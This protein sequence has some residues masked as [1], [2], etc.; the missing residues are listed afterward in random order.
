MPEKL[1]LSVDQF[2][3]SG[4]FGRLMRENVTTGE[5]PFRK[6]WLQAIVDQVEVSADV[7]RIVGDKASLQA[8]IT[9]SSASTVA[10][11]S[12]FCTEVALPRG[13]EPLFSP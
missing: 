9:G 2:A 4:S 10:G 1:A 8:A 3:G 12:Q 13:I 5:I 11:C 7:I 6:A